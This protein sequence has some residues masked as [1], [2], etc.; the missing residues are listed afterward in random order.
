MK[1]TDMRNFW[2]CNKGCGVGGFWVES[3]T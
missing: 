1:I 2:S 3:D